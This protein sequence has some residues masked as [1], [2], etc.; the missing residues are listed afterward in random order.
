MG[1]LIFPHFLL[2]FQMSSRTYYDTSSVPVYDEK[3]Y[4]N[5]MKDATYTYATKDYANKSTLDQYVDLARANSLPVT[6]DQ[7]YKKH[8]RIFNIPEN[9]ITIK[10][11]I[12][13]IKS[14]TKYMAEYEDK[15]VDV[16]YLYEKRLSHEFDMRMQLVNNHDWTTSDNLLNNLTRELGVPVYLKDGYIIYAIDYVNNFITTEFEHTRQTKQFTEVSWFSKKPIGVLDFPLGTF[17]INP[18]KADISRIPEEELGLRYGQTFDRARGVLVKPTQYSIP[19][20]S[21]SNWITGTVTYSDVKRIEFYNYTFAPQTYTRNQKTSVAHCI[22]TYQIVTTGGVANGK[23]KAGSTLLKSASVTN[24]GVVT[25][26]DDY[27]YIFEFELVDS[28]KFSSLPDDVELYAFLDKFNEDDDI[29]DPEYIQ[30]CYNHKGNNKYIR[31]NKNFSN[32]PNIK[33]YLDRNSTIGNY[34]PMIPL[35]KDYKSMDRFP[36]ELAK[37][38]K[39]VKPTGLNIDLFIKE[40]TKGLDDDVRPKVRDAF[41]YFG[42]PVVSKKP[43]L[44]EYMAKYAEILFQA[45][46]SLNFRGLTNTNTVLGINT[47]ESTPGDK[48]PVKYP[49]DDTDTRSYITNGSYKSDYAYFENFTLI[50]VDLLPTPFMWGTG[51]N[52]YLGREENPFGS[53]FSKLGLSGGH[54]THVGARRIQGKLSAKTKS[55]NYVFGYDFNY[56]RS[57]GGGKIDGLVSE[58]VAHVRKCIVEHCFQVTPTEYIRAIYIVRNMATETNNLGWNRVNG[59]ATMMLDKAM[60][61]QM[62]GRKKEQIYAAS[63]RVLTQVEY[64]VKKSFWQKFG[65]IITMA[66]IIVMSVITVGTTTAPMMAG[67]TTLLTV[68]GISIGIVAVTAGMSALMAFVSVAMAMALTVIGQNAKNPYI[69]IIAAVIQLVYMAYQSGVTADGFSANQA[70]T[71]MRANSL[72]FLNKMGEL[73]SA[74]QGKEVFDIQQEIMKNADVWEQRLKDVQEVLADLNKYTARSIEGDGPR[75]S[76]E[77]GFIRLGDTAESFVTRTTLP[78]PGNMAIEF[79]NNFVEIMTELPTLDDSISKILKDNHG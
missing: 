14:F 70:I 9:K 36:S 39:V 43:Y 75:D 29:T 26:T 53:I 78:N 51:R 6:L 33:P 59:K 58:H 34:F 74:M 55:L 11:G 40:Y 57:G 76:I 62:S 2:D 21:G 37:W 13:L 72:P 67:A 7:M 35:Y 61:N 20:Y 73:Y 8:R 48:P 41:I 65:F 16:V 30:I 4:P 71:A 49:P 22:A 68:G 31:I 69:K 28:R 54:I 44:V 56:E 52:A 5:F 64:S 1:E 45:Q 10:T 25:K 15:T 23:V 47:L 3:G 42:F 63:F 24:N 27:E 18:F 60:S 66:V 12:P 32:L 46:S 79:I 50:A 38:R 77:K 19:D 17:V